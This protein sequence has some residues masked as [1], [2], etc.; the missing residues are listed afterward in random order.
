[1]TRLWYALGTRREKAVPEQNYTLLSSVTDATTPYF[2]VIKIYVCQSRRFV[3]NLNNKTDISDSSRVCGRTAKVGFED[4]MWSDGLMRLRFRLSDNVYHT[5]KVVPHLAQ[6][7]H[8]SA[9]DH[10]P[11]LQDAKKGDVNAWHRIYPHTS[12]VYL[13][14]DRQCL[15]K[16]VFVSYIRIVYACAP[17][18]SDLYESVRVQL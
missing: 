15:F 17:S 1:M 2:S 13:Y 18:L 5:D 3:E 11:P 16:V 6:W 12:G 9:H 7:P 10:Y 8:V 14:Q 4:V